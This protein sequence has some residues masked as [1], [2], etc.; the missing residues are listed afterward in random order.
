VPAPLT[1][2][3]II[4]HMHQLGSLLRTRLAR[5]G[6]SAEPELLFDTPYSFDDQQVTLLPSAAA[7]NKGDRIVTE[8]TYRNPGP[9]TVHFGDSSTAEMCFSGVFTY[10]ARERDGYYCTE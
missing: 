3:A 7:L 8:C 10:P 2:F 5:A 1:L 6:S 9:D 4:P